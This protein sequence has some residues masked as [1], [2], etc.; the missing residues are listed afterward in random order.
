MENSGP[1]SSRLDVVSGDFIV[2]WGMIH[3]PPVGETTAR[4]PVE[5][6]RTLGVWNELT[7]HAKCFCCSFG[8][9]KINKAVSSIAVIKVLA[10]VGHGKYHA[11]FCRMFA[12]PCS[13]QVKHT[14]RI[15]HGS[16]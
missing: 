1:R 15:C 9:G 6:E 13:T 2:L 7:I 16:S 8:A 12:K 10:G 5:L 14:L 4:C 11:V 3:E